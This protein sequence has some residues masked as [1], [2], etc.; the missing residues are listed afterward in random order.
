MF[1]KCLTLV[2]FFSSSAIF[3]KGLDTLTPEVKEE[4]APEAEKKEGTEAPAQPEPAAE[5]PAPPAATVP[6]ET[7]PVATTPAVTEPV[8]TFERSN[9][10]KQIEN[11]MYVGT[12]IDVGTLSA[13]KGDWSSAA[14]SHLAIGYK[15]QEKPGKYDLYGT[16]RYTPFDVVVE[17]SG[18][19]YNG[20]VEGYHAGAEMVRVWKDKWD[21]V[22]FA[23][24]G[25]WVVTLYPSDAFDKDADLEK[26]GATVAAGGGFNWSPLDKVKIG[27]RASVGFGR[28]Q[29]VRISGVAEF[30]F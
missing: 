2:V 25:Y 30:A 22:A 16:F 28:F 23:E 20:V 24:L 18:L 29:S 11:K 9:I 8:Q 14:G 27:P 5:T 15:L 17:S 19:S 1:T 13:S 6:A 10:S 26:R 3:G 7:P 12:G 4:P 21:Y